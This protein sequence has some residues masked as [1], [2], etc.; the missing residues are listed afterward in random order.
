[1]VPYPL[2]ELLKQ[3]LPAAFATDPPIG[4]QFG[5]FLPERTF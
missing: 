2:A 5:V 1:M 3:I 4:G